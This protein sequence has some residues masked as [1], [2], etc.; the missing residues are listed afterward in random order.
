MNENYEHSKELMQQLPHYLIAEYIADLA[1]LV[2]LREIVPKDKQQQLSHLEEVI[3]KQRLQLMELTQ[4]KGI[5][6]EQHFRLFVSEK[7]REF[8]REY[9]S[10]EQRKRR[11]SYA[12]N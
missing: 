5:T 4:Q 12:D 8:Y 11:N 7:A 2:R 1:S 3:E 9:I 10:P 6:N